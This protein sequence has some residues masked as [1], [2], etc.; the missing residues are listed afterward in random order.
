MTSKKSAPAF[1]ARVRKM[2][3]IITSDK[4]ASDTAEKTK[5]G[6]AEYLSAEET[7]KEEKK[8]FDGVTERWD[9]T[10]GLNKAAMK[11]LIKIKALPDSKKADLLRTLIPGLEL[12]LPDQT[13]IFADGS[14]GEDSKTPSEKKTPPQDGAGTTTH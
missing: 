10:L 9:K 1:G 2:V 5:S 12:V 4:S 11:I 13:D 14:G 8:E 3:E 6:I 7:F